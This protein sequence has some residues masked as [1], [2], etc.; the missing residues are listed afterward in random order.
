MV[1]MGDHVGR[2][3]ET[4]LFVAIDF[5][6]AV[7][8]GLGAMASN[9]NRV[10]QSDSRRGDRGEN[11]PVLRARAACVRLASLDAEYAE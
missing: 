6:I 8:A 5:T 7:L 3:P 2:L 4:L 11:A 1:A 10:P 9:T